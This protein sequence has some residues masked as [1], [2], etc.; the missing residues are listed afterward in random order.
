MQSTDKREFWTD[1]INKQQAG[2]EVIEAYCQ[3]HGLS[4]HTFW[5]WRKK[6]RVEAR[7]QGRKRGRPKKTAA[8]PVVSGRF[9]PVC[10]EPLRDFERVSGLPDAK[11]LAEF[12]VALNG[13]AK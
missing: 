10:V 9:V 3:T 7:S 8:L 1:H 5:Y 13:G 12:I 2:S 6:L 4:M 11:W